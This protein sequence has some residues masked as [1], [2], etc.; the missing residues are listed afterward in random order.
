MLSQP[1]HALAV[2]DLLVHRGAVA[3]DLPRRGWAPRFDRHAC[4]SLALAYGVLSNFMEFVL[5]QVARGGDDHGHDFPGTGSIK[6]WF[7]TTNH[8]DVGILY[9]VTSL[10]FLVLGGGP[11]VGASSVLALRD[12]SS[13][14]SRCS[15]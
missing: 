9:V 8:K 3:D 5:T 14:C 7:V 13:L 4:S 6:R 2:S 12:C 1:G 11:H 15:R 10:F